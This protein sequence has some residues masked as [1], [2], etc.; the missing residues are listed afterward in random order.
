M[1]SFCHAINENYIVI[2]VLFVPVNTTGFVLTYAI[3]LP[4]IIV[5]VFKYWNLEC[6]LCYSA[7]FFRSVF[8]GRSRSK[9]GI[10]YSV[11]EKRTH[12]VYIFFDVKCSCERGIVPY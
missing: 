8:L 3:A 1:I 12:H 6:A 2:V 10:L 9:I 5:L 4:L 11:H 7:P